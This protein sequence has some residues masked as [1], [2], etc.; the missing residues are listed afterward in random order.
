MILGQGNRIEGEATTRMSAPEARSFCRLT[1]SV[2]G[3]LSI[4]PKVAKMTPGCLAR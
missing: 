4:S 3:T 1:L 2:P